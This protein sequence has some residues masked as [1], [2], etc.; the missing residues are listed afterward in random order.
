MMKSKWAVTINEWQRDGMDGMYIMLTVGNETSFKNAIKS[1]DLM[2]WAWFLKSLSFSSRLPCL[3]H[4]VCPALLGSP[5]TRKKK[6]ERKEHG[7]WGGRRK[8]HSIFNR[9]VFTPT[10]FRSNLS[11][12]LII[13]FIYKPTRYSKSIMDYFK[14]KFPNNILKEKQ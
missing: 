13:L 9:S 5:G 4:K 7:W 8:S 10:Q 12:I 2:K 3:L 1:H 14:R 6:K 11:V